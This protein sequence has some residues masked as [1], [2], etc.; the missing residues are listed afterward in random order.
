M[1]ANYCSINFYY[2]DSLSGVTEPVY[3][4]IVVDNLRNLLTKS[5]I[6]AT[7]SVMEPK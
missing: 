4:K 2:F 7:E 1:V 5:G 3:V 6:V